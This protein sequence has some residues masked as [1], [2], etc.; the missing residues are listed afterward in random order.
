[1]AVVAKIDPIE[2]DI[3]VMLAADLSPEARSKALADF[4]RGGLAE[5]QQI[6]KAA[7]GVVPP[8]ESFV[9]GRKSEALETVR[10][11]GVIVFEFQLMSDIFAWVRR[12]LIDASPRRS[13][14]YS[15]SHILLA[16]GVRVRSTDVVPDAEEY[17]FVN[18]QPYTR[19]L[20][21][22]LSRQ[23]PDGVYHVVAEL[24]ARR[25]GNI[26]RI[27]FGYATPQVGAINAWAAS[28]SAK[29]HARRNRRKKDA[30]EWLRRQPAIYISS[31]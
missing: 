3:Q 19:K 5:A 18:V 24:A 23:A 12:A 25:F 29:A 14:R 4:A 21:R 9:D 31:F 28:A 26:A 27:R 16:D 7:L 6:N 1:M 8:H 13:G 22:G 15:E 30:D 2:R 20:E 11:D 17:I 10:P